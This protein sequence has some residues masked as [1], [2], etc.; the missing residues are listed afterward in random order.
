MR[1]TLLNAKQKRSSQNQQQPASSSS[2]STQ[3]VILGS[4]P[5]QDLHP[6]QQQLAAIQRRMNLLNPSGENIPT[7]LGLGYHPSLH[8]SFRNH[9]NSQRENDAQSLLA[10]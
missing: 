6:W 3:P 7:D 8:T 1:T 4:T 10:K 9:Q 2:P 5:G